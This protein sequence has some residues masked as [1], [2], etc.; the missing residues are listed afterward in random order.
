MKPVAI[1]VSMLIA[2]LSMAGCSFWE[3]LPVEKEQE[4]DTTVTL[5]HQG[6]M[7]LVKAKDSSFRMGSNEND[8]GSVTQPVHKVSFTNDFWMDTTEVPQ[9]N[10]DSVMTAFCPGYLDSVWDAVAGAGSTYPAFNRNW[11][12][13]AL[14]CNARSKRDTL[15]TVYIFDS[16]AGTPGSG[17]GLKIN[18]INM[19]RSGYRLPTEAEWEYACRAGTSDE[20]YWGKAD[21]REYAWCSINSSSRTNPVAK[22]KPNRYGLYDMSGNVAEWC[23]DWYAAYSDQDSVDPTGPTSGNYRIQR[24]GCWANE[25]ETISSSTRVIG[26]SQERNTGVGFRVVK[27]KK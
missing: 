14:Y 21:S 13:A 19:S 18:A 17:C 26:S 23:N 22:R 15:D 16:I 25:V 1:V 27:R 20:F 12:D 7:V 11:H 24:G 8:R 9:G 2:A 4:T 3:D 10:Y 6:G 5:I